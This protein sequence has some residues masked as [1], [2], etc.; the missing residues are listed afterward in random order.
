[1]LLPLFRKNEPYIQAGDA[2]F[3]MYRIVSLMRAAL[4]Q[5]AAASV[6]ADWDYDGGGRHWEYRPSFPFRRMVTAVAG[7]TWRLRTN[8]RFD[9]RS[10]DSSRSSRSTAN[11]HGRISKAGA[12]SADA[13]GGG[14]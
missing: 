2:D 1:M 12:I 9:N 11:R 4:R 5:P 13:A 14:G 10:A 7:A 8:G 6:A 3:A